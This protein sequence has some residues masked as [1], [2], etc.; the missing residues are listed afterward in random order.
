MICHGMMTPRTAILLK[1]ER[2]LEKQ[3]KQNIALGEAAAVVEEALEAKKGFF[4]EL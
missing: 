1:Q 4:M 3:P 2:I